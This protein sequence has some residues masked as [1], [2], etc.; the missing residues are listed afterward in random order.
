MPHHSLKPAI[1]P[2]L[3]TFDFARLQEEV[4]KKVTPFLQK[5]DYVHMDVMDGNFVND[6]TF[7][8]ATIKV[9]KENTTLQLYLRAY[10][11]NF[12]LCKMSC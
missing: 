9:R 11:D 6:I 2:S 10:S 5:E 8:S 1:G 4:A 3:L 12:A 7:S